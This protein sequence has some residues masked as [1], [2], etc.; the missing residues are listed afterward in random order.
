M[1]LNKKQKAVL[2]MAKFL[3]GQ[4]LDLLGK[5]EELQLDEHAERC[6]RLHEMSEELLNC[7]NSEFK[8]LESQ[9]VAELYK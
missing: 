3:K 8:K 9:D 5:L 1:P 2:N 6:D 7:L 4:S